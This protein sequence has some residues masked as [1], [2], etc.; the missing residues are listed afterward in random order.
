MTHDD[1]WGEL[2]FGDRMRLM[3]KRPPPLP[4]YEFGSL[5]DVRDAVEMQSLRALEM[6]RAAGLE[7]PHAHE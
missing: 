2:T 6:T 4:A 5:R 7:V 3:S 1:D